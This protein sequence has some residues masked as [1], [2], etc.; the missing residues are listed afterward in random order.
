MFILEKK[1]YKIEN[2]FTHL[3]FKI[4]LISIDLFLYI[5]FVISNDTIYWWTKYKSLHYY[6]LQIDTDLRPF[7]YLL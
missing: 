7:R 2:A 4:N 1:S 3:Y 5:L 6:Y